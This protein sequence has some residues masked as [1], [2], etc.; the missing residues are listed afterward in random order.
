MSDDL[1]IFFATE[2]NVMTLLH[3]VSFLCKL[4]GEHINTVEKLG[5]FYTNEPDRVFY[6]DL[7]S[8]LKKFIVKYNLLCR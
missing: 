4:L 1:N 6:I 8:E 5:F 2:G 3:I 7:T